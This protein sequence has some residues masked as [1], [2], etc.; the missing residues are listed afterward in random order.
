MESWFDKSLFKSTSSNILVF[1]SN[2]AGKHG[3]GA[4]KFALQYCGA[5]Y[6]IPVGLQGNS[7]AIPTKNEYIRTLPLNV[8]SKYV[9]EF[10]QFTRQHPE[11]HF[12]ITAIG[13]G[14]AGYEHVHIAPMFVDAPRNC[15]LPIEWR[16]VRQDEEFSL[17]S[18]T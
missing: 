13:T 16:S 6:G 3:K 1:G 10:I 11:L 8:I 18:S 5:K 12:Y 7:Y 15:V 4:A 17:T 14:L 9:K 2:L